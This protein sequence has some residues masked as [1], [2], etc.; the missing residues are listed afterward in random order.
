MTT[1]QVEGYLKKEN[2]LPW[3]TSAKQ[4][5]QEHAS[6]IDMT[7]MAFETVETA[8][9]LQMQ[10]IQINKLLKQQADLHNRQ[11]VE[12]DAA[13]AALKTEIENINARL[14]AMESIVAGPTSSQNGD[15]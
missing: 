5:E 8:E 9:N 2:H 7:R 13:I 4:E 3:M 11:L 1:D 15:M 12:K 14:G 10:L 6:V